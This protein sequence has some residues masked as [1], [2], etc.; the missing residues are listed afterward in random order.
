MDALDRSNLS[1][2]NSPI[3]PQINSYLNNMFKS[4]IDDDMIQSW[5][6]R[7]AV[8]R[9]FFDLFDDGDSKVTCENLEN[10][11]GKRLTQNV[12]DCDKEMVFEKTANKAE[13]AEEQNT[14][15]EEEGVSKAKVK[16]V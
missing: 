5:R 10:L 13:N 9:D 16:Q 6:M 3:E 14:K 11:L 1:L 7:R 12:E 8:Q 15:D 4:D 2:D